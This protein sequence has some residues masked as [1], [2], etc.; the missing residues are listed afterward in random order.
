MAVTGLKII[1]QRAAWTEF[2]FWR[3]GTLL[4]DAVES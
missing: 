2:A 3:R 1:I 4:R